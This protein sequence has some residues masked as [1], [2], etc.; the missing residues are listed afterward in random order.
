MAGFEDLTVKAIEA[1][2]QKERDG[3]KLTKED[4]LLLLMSDG[5]WHEAI[6]LAYN[7]SWRFGGYLH[8]L[9][10]RGVNWEKERVPGT[11]ERVFKYRLVP[12]E[13]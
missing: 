13:D 1:A 12:K 11:A 10:Q 6:E 4:R 5:G 8:T 9:K 7:V 3:K 2:R